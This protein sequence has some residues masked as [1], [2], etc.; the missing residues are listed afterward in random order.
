MWNVSISGKYIYPLVG[1]CTGVFRRVSYH[2]QRCLKSPRMRPEETAP[3]SPR[4]LLTSTVGGR[5]SEVE[6]DGIATSI[7]LWRDE[8]KD[9]QQ[10]RLTERTSQLLMS[11]CKSVI[12]GLLD[13][14]RNRAL[15]ENTGMVGCEKIHRRG[16]FKRKKRGRKEERKRLMEKQIRQERSEQSDR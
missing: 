5:Q 11:R 16:E 1:V 7:N 9:P 2:Y 10:H 6:H 14:P 8:W 4:H 12:W 15:K 13:R 3:E